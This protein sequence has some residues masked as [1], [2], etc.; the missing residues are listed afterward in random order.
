MIELLQS[1]LLTSSAEQNIFSSAD[2]ISSCV[3]VLAEFGD[4]ALQTSYDPW[5]S[6]VFH[7]RAKIRA[8]L[9]KTYRDVRV[10]ANVEMELA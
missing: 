6:V 5:G 7:G 1:Y 10:A 9:R 3:E 8:N 2:S 4:R